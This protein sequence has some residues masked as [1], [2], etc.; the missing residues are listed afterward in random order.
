MTSSSF[1]TAR[2]FGVLLLIV[3]VILLFVNTK[4]ENN[5]PQ[6][7]HTPIIALE[8]IQSPE[9]VSHFFEVKDVPKYEQ[10]L[11][12]GNQIDYLFMLLYSGLLFCIAVGIR[13]ITHAGTM[14]LAMLFCVS[15]LVFD[16][17]E[18]VQLYS[19]IKNYKAADITQNLELLN[20]FTWLKWSSIASTFLLISPFFFKGKIVHQIIGVL[21]IVCFGLCIAAFLHHGIL[22][23]IF[24]SS[25]VIVFLLLVVF[26]FTYKIVE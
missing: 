4:P 3:A 25:V 11:L 17:L 2:I 22:N 5:L 24:A 10:D 1:K 9:E 26:V 21:C 7:F 13:K 16:G 18:N 20:I 15:M 6:G 12:L 19:I 14:Y 23:E 8:F